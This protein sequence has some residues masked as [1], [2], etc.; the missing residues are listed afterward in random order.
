MSD[1]RSTFTVTAELRGSLY[2][3]VLREALHHCS[4]FSLVERTMPVPGKS[5]AATS[6][7][8]SAYLLQERSVSEWPGTR[9]LR[10]SAILREYALSE[11]SVEQL[12]AV[13][14]IYDWRHPDRPEDLILWRNAAEPWL[15]TIAHERDAYF[16]LTPG[17][18]QALVDKLPGL[19][20]LLGS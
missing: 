17:E 11:A 8:L 3:A 13:E 16:K 18:R 9:L 10:G 6:A 5:V 12:G 15:V 2:I 7:Q 20:P 4:R 19:F 1:Q 14:G